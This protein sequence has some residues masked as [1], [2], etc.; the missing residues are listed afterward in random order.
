MAGRFPFGIFGQ[1]TDELIAGLEVTIKR[2]SDG[3]VVGRTHNPGGGEQQVADNNDGTYFVDDLPTGDYSVYV[4]SDL[5][6]QDELS[7]IPHVLASDVTGHISDASK[8]RTINDA[9]SAATDLWSAQ[10]IIQELSGKAS[11]AHSHA[12]VYATAGHNHDD[13]YLGRA[14]VFATTP[15]AQ[16]QDII[17]FLVQTANFSLDASDGH[18]LKL[19]QSFA[20]ETILTDNASLCT[21]MEALQSAILGGINSVITLTPRTT[22]LTEDTVNAG[23]I[24]YKH[25]GVGVYNMESGG[26]LGIYAILLGPTGTPIRVPLG[27]VSWSPP[28]Q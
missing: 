21:N 23:K 11:A 26:E 9:G 7:G 20:D 8:H 18:R 25:S 14:E 17:D 10:K 2:D 13:N 28:V 12:G 15:L 24:Y 16:G 19:I 4:G 5:V 27:I 3:T 1:G 22:H 6:P